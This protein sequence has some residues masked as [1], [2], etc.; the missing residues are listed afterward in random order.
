[1]QFMELMATLGL[2][3]SNYNQG[4]DAAQ[5]R[6][7]AVG[8]TIMRGVGVIGAASAAAVGFAAGKVMDLT[9]QAVN[10]YG[11]Y[12][13]LTGGI[14]KLF[15]TSGMEIEAYAQSVGATVDDIRDQYESLE[16]AEALMADNAANA[17]ATAGVSAN[18]YMQ[19][20]TSFSAALINSLGGD[21]EEAARIAD[22]AMQDLSDN[23]NTFGTMTASELANVYSGLARGNYTLL[24]NLNLGFAGS[25]EGMLNLLN[26]SGLFEE[27]LESLDGI[28][29]DQMLLA[30]HEVQ[31]NMGIAGTTSREAMG[32]IQGSMTMLQGAWQNL[33]TGLGDSEA[34]LSGLI[35]NVVDSA[36]AVVHNIV[37]IAQQ[38]MQGIASLL[39]QLAP[40][41]R[42]ELP[43][44]INEVLPA[45][46]DA[47]T[48]IIEG[49]AEA[50]PEIA[51]VLLPQIP[52][53][54]QR[55]V[56]VIMGLIPS[57]ISIGG[58]VIGAVIT[59]MVEN[60]PAIVQAGLD[61]FQQLINAFSEGVNG[62]G[63][64]Q[65]V[66]ATMQIIEMIGTF[67]VEN[68]PTLIT[69][70]VELITQLAMMLTDPTNLQTMIDL[71]LQLILAIADG[72][73]QSA[74]ALGNAVVAVIGNLLIA[75]WNEL[76]NILSTIGQLLGE[77]AML[78]IGLVGG[79]MGDSYDEVMSKLTAI[80]DY[81]STSLADFWTGISTWVSDVATS[82]SGLWENIVS[83]FTDGITNVGEALS[84]W[85]DEIV[86]FFSDLADN[87]LTWAG[88]M[89]DNF[90]DGLMGG[91][92]RVGDA[93]SGIADEVR[94]F[95]G[96]SEPERGPLSNFHTFA[97]DMIDLW[98]QTLEDSM[99][100]MDTPL[101]NVS[102]HI[103]DGMSTPMNAGG[104]TGGATDSRPIVIPVYIG[105]EK[106]DEIIVDSNQRMAF[107]S[108]GR[109]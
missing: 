4:L 66:D 77:V 36:L 26:A 30:I 35:S 39:T 55:V 22:I 50:L 79:L 86:A 109:A 72:L 88:D 81:V 102:N 61:A 13:Q 34:D 53:I 29:F 100:S 24:D 45:L 70:A 21:T 7:S 106:I 85:W 23:A 75:L 38:A 63:L 44:L 6:V 108:G 90:V 43:D 52:P 74:P 68:A 82:I 1:M 105:N 91:I 76:P 98:N 31:D 89:I 18:E 46:L 104:Y 20:V 99:S 78:V 2:D 56:P 101:T 3:A 47:V 94:S 16:R 41:L 84:G 11:E 73:V 9:S 93:V 51:G 14:S 69:S 67:L 87:A 8:G 15:G 40:I 65:L 54:I 57:L 58:E 96:F 42:D 5:S 71:S 64:S 62:D 32:T 92:S 28:S 59:G 27:Q 49:V 19:T 97:P 60:A 80:W 103:A 12:E 10:A 95:L 25:Q 37:P 17:Y 33:L 48:A 107:I 83:F